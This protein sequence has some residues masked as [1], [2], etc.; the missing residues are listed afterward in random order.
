[1]EFEKDNSKLYEYVESLSQEG[2]ANDI[3]LQLS[4]RKR[5]HVVNGCGCNIAFLALLKFAVEKLLK[6][7][8]M[9]M[10]ED[11]CNTIKLK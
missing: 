1:M 3:F 7:W 2:K 10:Y 6:K 4:R 8:T 11:F 9:Q 5:A